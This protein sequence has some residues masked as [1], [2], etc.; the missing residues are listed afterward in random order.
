MRS[1]AFRAGV[2]TAMFLV[3]D[4]ASAT[5]PTIVRGMFGPRAI[6]GPVAPQPRTRFDS[7]IQRGPSGQILGLPRNQRFS[8]DASALRSSIPDALPGTP[9]APPVVSRPPVP[10]ATPPAVVP[11]R[12]GTG[13]VA[14]PEPPTRPADSWFRTRG[15]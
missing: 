5:E 4:S 1:L 11:F 14:P 3:F 2:L 10:P 13:P 15:R 12:P 8:Y 9:V 6:G 7:G